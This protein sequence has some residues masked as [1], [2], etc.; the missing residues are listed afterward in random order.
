MLFQ[1]SYAVKQFQDE[2]YLHFMLA[3]LRKI[4]RSLAESDSARKYIL[5]AI[6]EI[7]LVMIGILLALQI[8]NWNEDRKIS[9]QEAKIYREIKDE[10]EV[11]VLKIK[12]ELED[13]LRNQKSTKIVLNMMLHRRNYHDSIMHHLRA[14]VDP[15]EFTVKTSAFESLKSIGIELL[16]KDSLRRAITDMY[17]VTLPALGNRSNNLSQYGVSIDLVLPLIQNHLKLIRDQVME[18]WRDQIWGFKN[19]NSYLNDDLLKVRLHHVYDRRRRV[20]R[21]HSLAVDEIEVLLKSI[22][23]ELYRIQ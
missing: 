11:S 19:Y 14:S 20:I 13:H 5:Y 12:Q 23:Q 2:P 6:G 22:E 1:K 16:S 4:R 7:L 18:S 21:E 15:E 17:Q 3:F 8:N 10:L 9:V